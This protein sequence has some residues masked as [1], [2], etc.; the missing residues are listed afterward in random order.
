[1]TSLPATPHPSGQRI[2]ACEL[3][4]GALLARYHADANGGVGH[5][6]AYV[7]TVQARVS[8]AD[9]VTA[10]YRSRAF[11][12]ERA[13]LGVVA[14]RPADDDDARRLGAAEI[15]RFS[16]W[17]VE[18]REDDQLLM[19]D[20]SGLTRSWLMVRER[21]GGAGAVGAETELWF[22]SAVV[23]RPSRSGRPA[24]AGWG[25]DLSL[26]FHRLYSRILLG[27]ALRAHGG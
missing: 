2:R 3:P 26:P 18:A 4:D 12:P 8:L 14:R 9:H 25:F 16:A 20:I 6:D 22:G 23:P 17:D 21:A 19:R 27:S 13:L 10:F 5:V 7:A 15:D 24:S 1:M 11:K